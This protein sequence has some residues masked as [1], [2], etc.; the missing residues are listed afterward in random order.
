VTL[1]CLDGR[2]DEADELLAEQESRISNDIF[3][4]IGYSVRLGTLRLDQGRIEEFVAIATEQAQLLPASSGWWAAAAA[5]H[6]QLG[7]LDEARR[8]LGELAADDFLAIRT[9]SNQ[10][11]AAA[12]LAYVCAYLGEVQHAPRLYELL[13]PHSGVLVTVLDAMACL[14]PADRFLGIYAAM[15]GDT[16]GAAAHFRA[17]LEFEERLF[18]PPQ[19]AHTRYWWARMLPRRDK[20]AQLLDQSI[21]TA[22]E[23]GMAQLEKEAREL[24]AAIS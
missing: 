4:A 1:A 13:A 15:V 12:L 17:A 9:G 23:L 8:I 10:T 21:A 18:S 11:V 20:T 2:F 14:G 24:R 3:A 5:G 16:E 19:M 7:R 22:S 6:A